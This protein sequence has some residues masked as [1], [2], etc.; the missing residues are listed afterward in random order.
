MIDKLD[1]FQTDEIVCPHCGYE[2]SE[3]YEY[4]G[5]DLAEC[6]ECEHTFVLE[7]EEFVVYTTSKVDW[8]KQWRKYNRAQIDRAEWKIW[9]EAHTVKV[10]FDE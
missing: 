10:V 6:P 3:S 8:L 1:T 4:I 5:D 7:S 2:F 9:K